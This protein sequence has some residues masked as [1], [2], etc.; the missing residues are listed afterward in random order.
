MGD[1]RVEELRESVREAGA[2]LRGE[3]GVA[4]NTRVEDLVGGAP[5]GP[6]RR[7]RPMRRGGQG[8]DGPRPRG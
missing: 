1:A 7:P 5:V 8:V 2:V 3:W 6:W 4:R